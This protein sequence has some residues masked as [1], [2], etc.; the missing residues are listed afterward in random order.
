MGHFNHEEIKE[1][2]LEG[3]REREPQVNK[4]GIRVE[5]QQC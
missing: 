4:N 3:Y 1:L 5:V 2:K